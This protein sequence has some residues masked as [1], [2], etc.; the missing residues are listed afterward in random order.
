M[1]FIP[2]V[3]KWIGKVSVSEHDLDSGHLIDG[4]H[5]FL[6]S[7][8]PPAFPS[9]DGVNHP[10]FIVCHW[11]IEGSH[12]PQISLCAA[13]KKFNDNDNFPVVSVLCYVPQWWSMKLYVVRA[14]TCSCY[15][16]DQSSLHL[17]LFSLLTVFVHPSVFRAG[18]LFSAS[19]QFHTF[20][21]G[22]FLSLVP[23]FKSHVQTHDSIWR[24]KKHPPFL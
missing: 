13:E 3:W 7:S 19:M 22:W 9:G 1:T 6:H 17:H 14:S 24:K 10:L 18:K 15:L 20:L 8:S 21:P 2:A 11:W 23:W 5:W 16:C 4:S 12:I